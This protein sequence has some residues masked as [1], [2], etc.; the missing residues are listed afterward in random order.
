M[1]VPDHLL[2]ACDPM[3]YLQGCETRKS[4]QDKL[5]SCGETNPK[6]CY[7]GGTQRNAYAELLENFGAPLPTP[8]EVTITAP[9]DG[10]SVAAG[11]I[12]RANVTDPQGV[13]RVELYIDN[14]LRDT[15]NVPPYIFNAPNDLSE[16]GHVVRVTGYD[17]FGTA[18][19]DEIDV[20]I[21]EPCGGDDDCAGDEA[22]VDGR[23]VLGPGSPGGLGEPCESGANCASGTCGD[24]GGER[25]C[26]EACNPGAD[27]C[28]GGFRCLSAGG[29][30]G[31]CWPGGDG[32]G[33]CCTIAGGGGGGHEDTDPGGPLALGAL[34]A[35]WLAWSVRR[36][37]A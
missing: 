17:S 30:Q 22:C 28:P 32:G 1:G 25:L 20:V 4:F 18:G 12:V 10:A 13:D 9:G 26:T 5:S 36:R 11:F 29:G 21:G 31:A 6:Q 24:V 16:G 2:E 19:S 7:C 37:R 8:P 27:G 34:V 15:G 35:L 14:Q 23:C 3:T 33:G